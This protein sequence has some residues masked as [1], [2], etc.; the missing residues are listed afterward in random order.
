MS[1]IGR[2]TF[3]GCLVLFSIA[4]LVV[5]LAWRLSQ[6]ARIDDAMASS[7][8]YSNF[9]HAADE[10]V[11]TNSEASISWSA[12]HRATILSVSTNTKLAE[13]QRQALLRLADTVEHDY[14]IG[15]GKTNRVHVEFQ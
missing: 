11:F 2:L 1:T 13:G 6:T 12:R 15:S 9:V 8:I 10:T 5:L 14:E 3:V 7:V 4:A